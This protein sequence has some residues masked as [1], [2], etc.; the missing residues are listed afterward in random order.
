MARVCPSNSSFD[1]PR[2]ALE[3]AYLRRAIARSRGTAQPQ[4]GTALAP[5]GL[6]AQ[7]SVDAEY[8]WINLNDVDISGCWVSGVNATCPY[9]TRPG[10]ATRTVVVSIIVGII[11][12][13]LAGLTIFVKCAANRA[14][15]KRRRR[16]RLRL[17]SDKFGEYEG[18]PS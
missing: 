3:N 14:G 9:I 6:S 16:R 4:I 7:S 2:T 1:V 11:I 13:I 18:V 12:L 17:M 10:E 8:I 15:V 5:S